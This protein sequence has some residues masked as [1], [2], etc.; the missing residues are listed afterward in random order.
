[1]SNTEFSEITI[2]ALHHIT[3]GV[4]AA[5]FASIRAQAAQYCPATAAKYANINPASIN[6]ASATAMGNACVAEM[7]PFKGAFAQPR[8]NAAIDSAFPK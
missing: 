7:G 6:R 4:G 1:M 8:I 2:E 5:D 3:G